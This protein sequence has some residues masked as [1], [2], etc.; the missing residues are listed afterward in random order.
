[1]VN[2]KL[3]WLALVTSLSI[4]LLTPTFDTMGQQFPPPPTLRAK[5]VSSPSIGDAP[6]TVTFTPVVTGGDPPYAY[7]WLFDDGSLSYE[8]S[9]THVFEK[10]GFYRVTMNL[11]DSKGVGYSAFQVIS[12]TKGGEVYN[13][14]RTVQNL[15]KG[16][17]NAPP[18]ATY[19]ETNSPSAATTSA[20]NGGKCLIATAAFGSELT[21]QV[22]F[23]RDFR[24][25]NIMSTVSGSS[26]MNV[27]NAWYYSFSPYVADYERQQPWLQQTIKTSIY[28][29][30]GILQASEKVYSSIDG[31]YGVLVAGLI[32][33]SMIGALYFWPF[34]ISIKSVWTSKF[35][36]KLAL[37]LLAIVSLATICSIISGNGYALMVTTSLLV[38]TTLA[39]SAI[40][41]AKTIAKMIRKLCKL[42]RQYLS[43]SE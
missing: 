13:P 40:L 3:V 30:L 29:L 26:F 37:S 7:E 18:N 24:D 25:R 9:P 16:V 11:K 17:D 32:A 33:S 35:N 2:P 36:Y 39:V 19:A 20:P 5:V 34:A 23:L 31:E 10:P 14:I 41:S 12:V 22:Q 8:A 4:V 38:L 43:L 1:M 28:P 6:L 27:F 15:T 21:P 42:R